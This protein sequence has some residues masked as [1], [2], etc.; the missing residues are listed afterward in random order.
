MTLSKAAQ[1]PLVCPP[2]ACRA[3]W[4][5]D[6]ACG[7]VVRKERRLVALEACVVAVHCHV[8]RF[9][10]VVVAIIVGGESATKK[11]TKKEILGMTKEPSVII[12]KKY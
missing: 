5:T 7:S 12:F 8:C 11:G 10:A 2:V 9:Q 3:L 4:E 6:P 1:V